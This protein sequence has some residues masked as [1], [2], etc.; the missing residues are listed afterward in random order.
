V[1]KWHEYELTIHHHP[2]QTNYAM[3]VEVEIDGKHCLFSGDNFYH[4][5]QYTGSGGWSGRNSG[6]PGGYA[7]TA[8]AILDMQP[9]WILAEHGGAFEF[10]A[11][12]FQRRVDWAN[13][14]AAAADALSP[15]G[16]HAYDWDPQRI[17]LEPTI[18]QAKPGE[19][20]ELTIVAT[21]PLKTSE[22]YTLVPT[23]GTSRFFP[24][25][26]R[27]EVPGGKT[28]RKQVTLEVPRDASAG[29]LILPLLVRNQPADVFVVL[30][31]AP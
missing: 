3:G 29:R 9:D 20:I 25:A 4:A 30:E 19:K 22:S 12:D 31:I 17:R 23:P 18:C 5:D 2:G 13:K 6:L 26:F 8:K 16:L 14:A 27:I 28:V 15:H 24:G 11:A 7:A 1:V 21:N 10:N